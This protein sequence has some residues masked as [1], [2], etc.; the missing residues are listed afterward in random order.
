MAMTIVGLVEGINSEDFNVAS[1]LSSV[2]RQ[3]NAGGGSL[4]S[5]ADDLVLGNDRNTSGFQVNKEGLNIGCG[6]RAPLTVHHFSEGGV[7]DGVLA[8]HVLEI[9]GQIGSFGISWRS[10]ELKASSSER[11]RRNTLRTHTNNGNGILGIS[12]KISNVEF[13]EES[14]IRS[15]NSSVRCDGHDPFDALSGGIDPRQAQIGDVVG[16]VFSEST[17]IVF[18]G[19][20]DWSCRNWGG[21]N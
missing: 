3:D 21:D 10:F 20:V 4:Q 17:S 1:V 8:G 7:G 9:L 18:I 13:R 19:E 14:G 15:G 16:V 12:C 11:K 6:R 2:D 5:S